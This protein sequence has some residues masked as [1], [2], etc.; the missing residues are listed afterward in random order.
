MFIIILCSVEKS[1]DDVKVKVAAAG[2]LTRATRVESERSTL[3]NY[4]THC[5]FAFPR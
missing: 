5:T 3:S 2:N 4:N 1:N